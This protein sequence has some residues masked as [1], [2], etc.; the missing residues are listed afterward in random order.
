MMRAL[1]FQPSANP[2]GE[3]NSIVPPLRMT[4]QQAMQLSLLFAALSLMIQTVG[5]LLGQHFGYGL[6]RDEL[7]YI[8][9]GRHLAWGYVDLAPMAALQ[10]HVSEAL[11]GLK[12]Q[13]LFRIFSALAGSA[14][15]F[16]T[17]ILVWFLGG[18]RM[19]QA[20]AMV[21]VM[22]AP[23]YL[24]LDSVLAM[25]SFESMFWMSCLLAIIW[26]IRG[27]SLRRWIAFGISGGLGLLNKPSMTFFLFGV[28]G[29]LLLTPERRLLWSRW[30]LIAVALIVGIAMPFMVWQANRHWPMWEL[31]YKINHDD[32]NGNVGPLA[33]LQGQITMFNSVCIFLTLPGLIWLLAAKSARRFRWIGI[34]FLGMLAVMMRAHALNYYVA[35][36]YPILFAAGAVANQEWFSASRKTAWL[37]PA[38]GSVIAVCGAITLP[39]VLP[40]LPPYAAAHYFA[41]VAYLLPNSDLANESPLLQILADRLGWHHFVTDVATVYAS[42]PP[43]ERAQA[44]IYCD[45]YGEASAINVYGPRHGLPTAVSGHQNYFYWGSNGY[46]GQVLIV[47]G[48]SKKELQKRFVSVQEIERVYNPL[49]NHFSNRPIYLCRGEKVPLNLYW[50]L[51]K[52]WY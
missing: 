43:K 8:T 28:L 42:L 51:A 46:T 19:A 37:L 34:M 31:L 6:F 2:L 27:G 49:A 15:V 50:P 13:A 25:N 12:N 32:F 41:K 44:G 16:I 22:V 24:A 29:G 17:G 40:V 48:W 20:L 14:R 9:C 1:L 38:L 18:R 7:Y 33:F 21:A 3:V 52:D 30:T 39:L 4:W 35:P 10:A 47:I 45:N 23:V 11:F 5:S 36:V 26:I